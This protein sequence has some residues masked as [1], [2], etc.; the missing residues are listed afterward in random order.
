MFR[1]CTLT[2]CLAALAFGDG[3]K[4]YAI[5][6]ARIH[7][8]EGPVIPRGNILME[9]GRIKALGPDVAIPPG[10]VVTEAE[11]LEAYPGFFDAVS[12]IGLMEAYY[13]PTG[14]DQ[15]ELGD[16]PQ[17]KAL[18]ALNPESANF[19]ITRAAGITHTSALPGLGGRMALGGQ[20]SVVGTA[21]FTVEEML[22]EGAAGL[23]VNI[24]RVST[25]GFDMATFTPTVRSAAEVKA[26]VER[27]MS[28]LRAWFDRARHHAAALAAGKAERDLALEALQP[29][30]KRE[31]PL[32]VVANKVREIQ[33]GLDFCSQQNLR[34][35]LV[36]GEEALKV[37]AQLAE[38]KIPV[39]LGPTWS[40]PEK[41][42]EPYDI[43]M[44]LPG[45]L[46]AAGIQVAIAS[47]SNTRSRRLPF[48]AGTA[49][50]Y[51][52]PP[53][54]GLKAITRNPAE[55]LGLGDRLG[56]L[57]P[58]KLAHILLTTGDP[59]ELRTQVKAV[60]VHG[61]PASLESRH[62]Q[63]YEKYRGR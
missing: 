44:T 2:L 58:G 39:I 60:F 50:A 34:M 40:L 23:V 6:N 10:A 20:A 28:T 3:P 24:P 54:E 17:L 43:A 27:K 9:Q 48:E 62:T 41:E 4:L 21:G 25:Q 33:L 11:G 59:L 7:T 1:L 31:K 55:M 51:G 13:L 38:R 36:G 35:V 42:D 22:V 12:Q 18:T 29:Y 63:L 56:T 53:E 14:D 45:E 57:R 16:N 47:F 61:Q 32:L 30:L 52:L 26:E 5:R 15:Q 8:L 37:K 49:I 46:H 19:A